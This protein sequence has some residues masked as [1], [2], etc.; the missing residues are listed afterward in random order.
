M[1]I[2]KK[3]DYFL[4]DWDGC[5]GDTLSLW[6]GAYKRV[7][8]DY[9]IEVADEDIVKKAFGNWEAASLFGLPDN[10]EFANKLTSYVSEGIKTVGLN[11]DSYTGLVGI[12]EAEKK[13]AVVTTS[14]RDLVVPAIAHNKI[15]DLIDAVVDGE[16]VERH[17]P[18]PE[19]V[20]L[21]IQK[22]EGKKN[23]T[24]MIGDSAKDILAGKNAG[25]ATAVFYPLTN[26][27]FYSTEEIRS[28]EPDFVFEN[29]EDLFED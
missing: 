3:F 26:K 19:P 9:G 22:L 24:I 12:K 20:L 18:D 1:K 11:G 5:L 25:V 16:E 6:L 4:F 15:E 17:K 13:I 27:V 28:W 8:A 14:L 29:F 21:A 7:F 23:R 10:E 2:I